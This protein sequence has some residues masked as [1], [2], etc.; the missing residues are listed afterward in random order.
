MPIVPVY[1]GYLSTFIVL[2]KFA[3]KYKD[4][5]DKY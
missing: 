2:S 1:F 3:G 4:F 5:P